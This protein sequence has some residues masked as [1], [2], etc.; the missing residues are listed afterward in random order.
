M[1]WKSPIDSPQFFDF[2]L[3]MLVLGIINGERGSIRRRASFNILA[4]G[5]KTLERLPIQITL[6]DPE[7]PLSKFASTFPFSARE[8]ESE[9]EYLSE[10]IFYI[11]N[12]HTL[13]S[14]KTK[15]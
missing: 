13:H 11:A 3:P 7:A 8:D 10:S 12:I 2:P 5:F 9:L 15:L 6:Q 1:A 4:N 14:R